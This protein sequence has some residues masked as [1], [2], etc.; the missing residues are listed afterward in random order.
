VSERDIAHVRYTKWDGSLHWHFD[1]VRVRSDAHGTWLLVPP[2]GEYRKGSE[3]ARTDEH[4]FV[5]L[6]PDGRWWTAYFNA[7]P[8]GERGSLVYVDVNT[9]VE[10]HDETAQLIDLDLDVVRRSDGTIEVLDEDEFAEHRVRFGYPRSLVDRARAGAER[11]HGLMTRGEEPFGIAGLRVVADEL[12]WVSGTIRAGHGAA[13]GVAGDP[14]FPGGTLALQAP[15]FA[16]RGIDISRFHAGTINVELPL[17]LE[18]RH[19]LARIE[20]LEWKPGYPA[21][22]FEFFDA[23]IAVDGTVAATLIYRPDPATKPEFD[24][25]SGTV[26]IVAPFLGGVVPGRAAS[27]WVDPDQARFVG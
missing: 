27:V 14:R 18:P 19:P 16:E 21:E 4:G 6:V 1:A 12:G 17:E 11:V 9:P 22:T 10:W 24:Q 25:P 2:G 15:H 26:E 23:R 3:P 13:S 7:V 8:R 5:V 20:Q